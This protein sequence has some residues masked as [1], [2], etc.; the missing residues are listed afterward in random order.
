VGALLAAV[1]TSVHGQALVVSNG[2]P[3]PVGDILSSICSA[4][5]VAGPRGRLPVSCAR[6]TAAVVEVV[7]AR[8]HR[9]DTPPLSRFLV[10]Q[11]TTAHWFDQRH[12]R[13]ALGWAPS[14]SLDEGFE[15]LT[16]WYSAAGA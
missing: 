16:R 15:A 8:R 5:G 6:A 2:E 3:R 14:T 1:D 9:Q 11:L 4:A 7:W 12:T 13:A 10:E